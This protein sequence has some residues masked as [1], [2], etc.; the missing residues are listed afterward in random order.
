MA[1][2]DLPPEPAVDSDAAPAKSLV[3][4]EP[5]GD[6]SSELPAEH[7]AS[8]VPANSESA[9]SI[10]TSSSELQA[11][12]SASIPPTPHNI[13][14]PETPAPESEEIHPSIPLPSL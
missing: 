6:S 12:S 2:K 10:A 9:M 13:P 4:S 7:S 8:L 1:D 5:N 11:S 3:L 14:L